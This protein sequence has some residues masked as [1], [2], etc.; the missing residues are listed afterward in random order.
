VEEKPQKRVLILHSLGRNFSPFDEFASRFQK[1]L[2]A[3]AA[4]VVEFF[5][6]SLES[7]RFNEVKGGT[8]S[9]HRRRFSPPAS[10]DAFRMTPRPSLTPRR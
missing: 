10:R 8:G 4:T 9:S 1:D 2:R 3:K 7:A 6:A 5:D